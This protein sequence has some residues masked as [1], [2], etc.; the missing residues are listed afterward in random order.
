VSFHPSYA[1]EDFVEGYRPKKDSVGGLVLELRDGVFKELCRRAEADPAR[2][3]LLIIDEINRG[4]IPKIFGELITLIELDKRGLKETL[5]QSGQ[6][7]SVPENLYMIGTMNTADRSIR[8]LDAALRR[9]FAFIELMP[10]ASLLEGEGPEGLKL[11]DLLMQ[12]NRRIV[13]AVGREKQVGHSYF[14]DAGVPIKDSQEFARIFRQEVMPLLQEFCYDDYSKLAEFVG[15]EIVDVE[16]QTLDLEVV[17]NPARLIEALN[18]TL[19]G[20]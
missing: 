8:V 19:L 12:L 4:N 11:N 2:K 1:Y 16:G 5:P 9:R 15:R 10:D 7:F 3:Y 14:L 13:K 6:E 18:K 20:T 17:E